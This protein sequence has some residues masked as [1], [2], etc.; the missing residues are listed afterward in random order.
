MDA[1]IE[2]KKYHF[3]IFP[4]ETL[5]RGPGIEEILRERSI[6]YFLKR[7]K[8]DFWVLISPKFLI[9]YYRQELKVLDVRKPF[10]FSSTSYYTVIISPNKYFIDCVKGRMGYFR[11]LPKTYDEINEIITKKYNICGFY[12]KINPAT[13][14][15]ENLASQNCS[16]NPDLTPTLAT[17]MKR[18]KQLKKIKELQ[19]KNI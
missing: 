18:T 7:K 13:I 14:K 4:Q 3:L 11:A 8:L 1:K 19:N 15:T 5:L 9:D 6:S 17:L 12:G 2:N 16:I 10:F